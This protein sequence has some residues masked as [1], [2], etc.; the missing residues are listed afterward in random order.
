M[1][2][3][4][5]TSRADRPDCTYLTLCGLAGG[6]PVPALRWRPKDALELVW[7]IREG[8]RGAQGVQDMP[9]GFAARQH[10]RVYA[11]AVLHG[12][13]MFQPSGEEGKSVSMGD[14]IRDLLLT[15]VRGLACRRV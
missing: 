8:Q 10:A 9:I 6:F 15:Q 12:P 5:R 13:Q 3:R 14:Y 1:L 11:S 4:A 2:L 7:A